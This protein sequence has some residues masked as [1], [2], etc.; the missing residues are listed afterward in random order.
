MKVGV[1]E[2]RRN[3]PSILA[4]VEGGFATVILTRSGRPIA[5]IVPSGPR[6][7]PPEG[8]PRGDLAAALQETAREFG[9]SLSDLLAHGLYFGWD[10]LKL[11]YPEAGDRRRCAPLAGGV[12]RGS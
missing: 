10:S 11:D 6:I 8:E 7:G 12:S 4:R 3:A 5:K 9:V 1:E 2:F